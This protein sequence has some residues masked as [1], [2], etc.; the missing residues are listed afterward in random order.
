VVD[1]VNIYIWTRI[2]TS[3]LTLL[4]AW[5]MRRTLPNAPRR[6]RI[7]GG[8]VGIVY[9]VLLPAILCAVK[10][11]YSEPLVFRWAP[12]LLAGGPVAYIVLRFAFHLT[13]RVLQI[14]LDRQSRTQ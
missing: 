5:Q 11:W 9:V 10:V 2:A 8:K 4:A 1:L 7:P 3:M 6:F 14:P 12:W 13:P